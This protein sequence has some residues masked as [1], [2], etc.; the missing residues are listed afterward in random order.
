MPRDLPPL[1]PLISVDAAAR[2][3]SFSK[4]AQ[5]LNLTHGA[6]SRAVQQVEQALGVPLFR[7]HNRRVSL[8]PEG[9]AFADCL[10]R[11]LADLRQ[12]TDRIRR[13]SAPTL[14]VSCEPTLTMRWLMPRLASFTEA[15]PECHVHLATGG[16]PVDFAHSGLDVAIRRADFGLPDEALVL[17]LWAEHV[18]PV[19]NPLA[20][21]RWGKTLLQAPRLHT[22]T[23]PQAWD[24][25]STTSG[26]ALP[27]APS[28]QRF[29]HFSFSLQAAVAGLGIAIG[30]LPLVA[31]DLA[32]GA[33]VAPF[34]FSP[35]GADYVALVPDHPAP[36]SAV[37]H[38]VEWC[39]NALRDSARQHSMAETGPS[40]G[41]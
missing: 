31:D 35:G 8:T 10:E 39:R 17:P 1:A 24:D 14:A 38:F 32:A 7:R 5:H 3:G 25:W 13:T 21:E 12:T 18:G 4:A 33:L 27:P 15:F 11:I 41:P 6:V 20:W 16:G 2:F 40:A 30:P 9:R 26:V 22:R 19:C 34:G 28:D 29:D 36:G 23:R 37:A